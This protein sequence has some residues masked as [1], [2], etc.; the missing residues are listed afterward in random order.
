MATLFGLSMDVRPLLNSALTLTTKSNVSTN[1]TIS[2]ADD[3]SLRTLN[4]AVNKGGG[5]SDI[6]GQRWARQEVDDG[7]RLYHQQ[8]HEEAMRKWRN[9]LR[10]L[11][12]ADDKFITLGYLAQANCEAGRYRDMLVYALH[13]IDLANENDDAYMRAEAYLNLAR[14]NE[15][16]AEFHKAVSYGRQSIQVGGSSDRDVLWLFMGQ[17][18]SV[19]IAKNSSRMLPLTRLPVVAYWALVAYY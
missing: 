10:R 4:L 17:V 8:K 15:R 6:M 1:T 19:S 2:S 3:T 13:Q 12:N 11:R 14:A 7:V 9:A 16:M 5:F 18:P